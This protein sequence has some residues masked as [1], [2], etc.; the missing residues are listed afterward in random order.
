MNNKGADCTGWSAPL[1]FACNKIEVS[2]DGANKVSIQERVTIN[3]S[4]KRYSNS[5]S[6]GGTI[7]ARNSMLTGN[8]VK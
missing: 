5:F 2:F 6:L 3:L 7:V 8:I 4:E 1:L